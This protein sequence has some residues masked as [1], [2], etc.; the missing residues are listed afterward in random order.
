MTV[1]TLHHKKIRKRENARLACTAANLLARY[2]NPSGQKCQIHWG[3][4][5]TYFRKLQYNVMQ[6]LTVDA[7]DYSESYKNAVVKA[8]RVGWN[9]KLAGWLSKLATRHYNI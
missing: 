4:K 7:D 2:I 9:Q 5:S 3:A 8:G 6:K 1:F